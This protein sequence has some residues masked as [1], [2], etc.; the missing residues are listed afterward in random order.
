MPLSLLA[1]DAAGVIGLH[2]VSNED[3]AVVLPFAPFGDATPDAFLSGDFMG[4]GNLFSD[5]LYR[6][7]AFDSTYTNAVFAAGS[8]WLDPSTGEQTG[9][10][11]ARGDTLVFAPG[12]DAG[13]DFWLFG[14]VSGLVPYSGLPRIRSMYVSPTNGVAGIEIFSR[15]RTI[16]ILA[17]DTVDGFP[18]DTPWIH[19]DRVSIGTASSFF[20]SDFSPPPE[21]ARLYFASDA[22]RDADSDGLPDA[23]ES[24]VYGTSPF[25]RDTDGD[26][27]DDAVEIAWGMNPLA[28]EGTDWS[29]VE[30]FE[31]PEVMAGPVHGQ[32]GWAATVADAAIVQTN[33]VHCG[34]NSLEVHFG[35]TASGANAVSSFA[36]TSKVDAVWVDLYSMATPECEIPFDSATGGVAVSFF[37]SVGRPV[38]SDGV[39][40]VTNNTIAIHPGRWVRQTYR[41]DYANRVWDCYIDGLLVEENLAMRGS[42]RNFQGFDIA[43][44]GYLDDISITSKRPLGLSSDGDTLPDEWEFVCFGSLDRDG[45]ADFDGDGLSDRDEYL[46]GTDPALACTDTDGDGLPDWWEL[47][48]GLDSLSADW[49]SGIFFYEPFEPPAISEG[50]I[51]GQNGWTASGGGFARVRRQAVH[52][53]TGALCVDSFGGD[54]AEAMK[55]AH[56]IQTQAWVVWMELYQRAAPPGFDES[57]VSAAAK[58]AHI[59]D[60]D[61]HPVATDG[62]SFVTNTA[63]AAK[64]DAWV[65]CTYRFDLGTMTWDMYLDGRLAF[66]GLRLRGSSRTL[67]ALEI[68]GSGGYA[69]DIVFSTVRPEGLSS[70]GDD[71][72]DEWEW[73]NFGTLERDGSGDSDGDGATDAEEYSAGTSPDAMDTDGDGIPDGWEIANGLNPLDASDAALDPDS[74]GFENSYEFAHGGNPNIPEPDPQTRRAGL[75]A[76]FYRPVGKQATMPEFD[77][78]MPS[79]IGIVALVDMP[80]LPWQKDGTSLGNYFACRLSGYVFV[81]E[82]GPRTFYLTS[83]AGAVLTIDGEAVISDSAAHSAR[84]RNSQ[85]QLTAGYHAIEIDCYKNTGAEALVLEWSAPGIER[86]IVPEGAFFHMP[87][88]G[89]CLAGYVPG[90][91][92]YCYSFSRALSSMPDVANLV[93]A[94]TCTWAKVDFP[95]TASVWPGAPENLKDRYAVVAEGAVYAPM[96]GRYKIALTSDDGAKLW[97]DG[98]PVID[99]GSTHSM[100]SKSAVLPMAEGL[101]DLR[102]EYFE[103]TGSAG[104]QLSWSKDGTASEIIPARF[105]FRKSGG[106]PVDSDGDEIPDW[107]EESHG[108]D[109]SNPA[110]AALDFDGDGLDNIAEYRAGTGPNRPDSDNDGMPDA[111]E[112]ANGTI[113]FIADAL[114]DL[115]GDGLVNIEEMR[116]A[117]NPLAADTDGDGCSDF[118]ELRNTHG[119]ALAADIAWGAPID[120]SARIPGG[121]AIAATG[122]W[123]TDIDGAIYAAER[124]GSLTW[125]LEVP[126]A[127]DALAVGIGQHNFYAAATTFDLSLYV[128]GLFVTRQIVSAPYGTRS[129]AFFFLPEIPAGAHEFR[130]VW[131]NWEVN[132]FLAVYDLRFVAFDGPDAGGNGI[133]DWK[134]H[135]ANESTALYDLPL[136]SLVSPLCI[137][138]RDLWRDILDVDVAYPETDA[139]FAT[140]K[141]IGDGFYADIPLPATGTATI[142]LRDRTLAESFNVVWKEFDVFAGE[143]ATNALA[144]RTGDALKIA[145]FDGKESEVAICVASPSGEWTAVTNWTETAATPYVFE[146][147]GLFLVT[148]AHRGLVFDDTARALVEVVSSRFP[149]RNPAIL[150]DAK[151]TLDCPGLSPRNV[152]EYDSELILDAKAAAGGGVRLSLETHASRDLGAVSRLDEAGAISDAVQ[153]TPVWAD[154]GTYY[155]IGGNFADGSQLVEVSLLLGAIPEGTTVTLSIFVKGVAFDDGTRTKTL[156]AEDFDENGHC[157]VRFIRARGVKTSVC[158]STRIYQ[159]GKLIYKN[160]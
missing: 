138:G 137:E 68:F 96:P 10:T 84:T 17:Q 130:L 94:A 58:A 115:D 21:F 131:H 8:G 127:M 60:K 15:G 86:E 132:T 43:G 142:S 110:D 12:D 129:D 67:T 3:V 117:T 150:M 119:N 52:A 159:D 160:R 42:P 27:I 39:S 13:L 36:V 105:F 122:T 29:A 44:E 90:V 133:P 54:P 111:W 140:I 25:L 6:L 157:V 51:A 118:L 35:R 99:N 23:L 109:V 79:T 76:E 7:Q 149:K 101:H 89:A 85:C 28:A 18:S 123:R 61:L 126:S 20:W 66:E 32:H 22:M 136:E 135:R 64:E 38:F 74:D 41:L 56:A 1:D 11:A 48:N 113:P 5:R 121:T 95:A 83:N 100:S 102:I 106:E 24:R 47:R 114:E 49:T 69:D 37:D 128:D 80:N 2:V 116:A 77:T 108:L 154:N 73:R 124:A 143:Y 57:A 65:R 14:R 158:H 103:N 91:D 87:E 46:A 97:L 82:A 146:T 31:P 16:D 9:L 19:R 81:P 153:I 93:P 30:T 88:D 141:T 92:V 45:S 59:F 147:N 151:E 107:W 98:T 148:V 4:D 156:T 62:G 55:A 40:F 78:L 72:P 33:I 53:G 112:V 26:G 50:D 71:M 152:I 63:I 104:L 34:D 139:A 134:D 70:D 145:P 120:A 125:T 75:L 144:I 155:R